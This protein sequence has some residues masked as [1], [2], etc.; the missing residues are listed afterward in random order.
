MNAN[1]TNETS[2][3]GKRDTNKVHLAFLD[4]IRAL[5]AIIVVLEHIYQALRF[6][7]DPPALPK[8]LWNILAMFNVGQAPVVVFICLSGFVLTFPVLKGNFDL[9]SF[10]K[11]RFQRIYP[12]YIAGLVFSIVMT[13]CGHWVQNESTTSVVSAGSLFTHTFLIH[14]FTKYI[15][16]LNGTHWTVAVEVQIYLLFALVWQPL[17]CKFGRTIPNV[18]FVVIPILITM[19]GY[20]LQ[21]EY[22]LYVTY[23]TFGG[24]TALCWTKCH[25]QERYK[26]TVKSISY[27]GYLMLACVI[28]VIMTNRGAYASSLQAPIDVL[29][30]I[31]TCL[32]ILNLSFAGETTLKPIHA[33]KCGLET[34]ILSRVASYSYSLY[35]IHYPIVIL[36]CKVARDYVANDI[37]R[38]AIAMCGLPISMVVSKLFASMFENQSSPVMIRLLNVFGATQRRSFLSLSPRI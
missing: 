24:L 23:F 19:A 29:I 1:R 8:M 12:P 3:S 35:L 10:A 2:L 38:V 17:A 28:G 34:R 6:S 20:S 26:A 22:Q 27:A 37:A 13:L 18:L 14:N 11:K 32:T 31:A 7:Y 36:M 9:G 25:A 33:I 15:T 5:M 16:S 4:G 21:Y 30:A